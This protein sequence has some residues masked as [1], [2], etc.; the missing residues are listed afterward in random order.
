[1][2]FSRSA[3]RECAK[4]RPGARN[5]TA[6]I[7]DREPHL[8]VLDGLERILIAYARMDA[9][10]RDDDMTS[11][12]LISWRRY[13]AFLTLKRNFL[14]GTASVK[15]RP[16]AGVESSQCQSDLVAVDF[17]LLICRAYGRS[18]TRLRAVFLKDK[19]EPRALA[20]VARRAD[21]LLRLFPS[22]GSHPLLLQILAG[23]VAGIDPQEILVLAEANPNFNLLLQMKQAKPIFWSCL[24]GEQ[25]K[26]LPPHAD[27]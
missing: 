2:P 6:P 13:A 21:E 7:L 18:A 26:T 14:T 12:R 10:F 19:R 3:A 9:A 27:Q 15:P 24:Q 8:L 22:F 4:S 25:K 5:S 16:R 1:M 23:E 11:A 17:I 20:L